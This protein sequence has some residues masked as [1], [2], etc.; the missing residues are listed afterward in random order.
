MT[1]VTV[2]IWTASHAYL[3]EGLPKYA[4]KGDAGMD[5]YAAENV[6]I[7][8]SILPVAVPTGIHVKIPEGYEIQVRP[9]SGMSAKTKLRIANSPGTI[10]SEYTGEI[11]VLLENNGHLPV[12]VCRG[13]RIAQLV[14]SEVPQIVWE[15]ASY[16][17]SLGNTE[18]GATGFGSS[19]I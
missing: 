4:K 15:T 7:L 11:K 3:E 6:T 12:Q 13:D 5:I 1:K 16:L 18:R 9:R 10:D 8:P 14:L 17:D 19:G 2:K